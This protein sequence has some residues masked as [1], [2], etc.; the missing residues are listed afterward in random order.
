MKI[1]VAGKGGSGKT[2]TAAILARTA[3]AEGRRVVAL[4]CDTNPNLAISLGLGAR[5]A[6]DLVAI[7]QAL[8]EGAEEHAPEWDEML[9]RFGADAP[10]S[11]RLGVVSAIENPEP[12]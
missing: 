3:G 5:V 4:D 6:E 7:R 8:E 2:T 10:D 12:G 11:V 1:V 9:H